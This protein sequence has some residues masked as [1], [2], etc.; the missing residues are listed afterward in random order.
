L[1]MLYPITRSGSVSSN[2]SSQRFN[3][4]CSLHTRGQVRWRAVCPLAQGAISH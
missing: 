4:S 2:R 3:S 1:M